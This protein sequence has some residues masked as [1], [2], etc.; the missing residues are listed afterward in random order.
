MPVVVLIYKKYFKK[1]SFNNFD[2][3]SPEYWEA[4]LEEDWLSDLD[5]EEWLTW[6]ISG[7]ENNTLE[8]INWVFDDY[9]NIKNLSFSDSCEYLE[10]KKI[11]TKINYKENS[12]KILNWNDLIWEIKI[13]WYK[14]WSFERD[15]H[16]YN[17]VEEEYR[18]K[19]FWKILFSLYS[20]LSEEN[21]DF[22]LPYE[23]YTNVVSMIKLYENFWYEVKHKVVRWNYLKLEDSDIKEIE[24]IIKDY[25]N[26]LKEEKLWYTIVLEKI[27][28]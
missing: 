15:I 1:M 5:K 6:W 16:L 4:I 20:K 13:S 25:K 10:S 18:W 3:N 28:E 24:K 21:S 19:W 23:E 27:E 11:F 22:I 2:K 8:R 26:W 12:L 14:D 7:I 9:K 17:V